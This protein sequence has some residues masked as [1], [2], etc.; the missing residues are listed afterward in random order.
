MFL[1]IDGHSSQTLLEKLLI[2]FV[3]LFVCFVCLFVCFS[4]KT[5]FLSIALAVL[6][7]TL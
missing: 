2:V 3:Y 6:E 1:S 5:G 4:F 7:L